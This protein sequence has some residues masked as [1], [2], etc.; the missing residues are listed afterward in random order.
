LRK[1]QKETARV[2]QLLLVPV[3]RY[4]GFSV[5]GSPVRFWEGDFYAGKGVGMACVDMPG[6]RV[7]IYNTHTC[8][9]YGHGRERAQLPGAP[10]KRFSRSPVVCTCNIPSHVEHVHKFCP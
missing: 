8:A 4:H 9:N 7:H 5:S 6:G 3:G 10:G 2:L 1:E